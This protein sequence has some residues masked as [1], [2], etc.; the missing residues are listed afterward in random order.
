MSGLGYTFQGYQ[1]IGL[2]TAAVRWF[3]VALTGS[4]T[5]HGGNIWSLMLNQ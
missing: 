5:T 3:A 1:I 2:G 4:R